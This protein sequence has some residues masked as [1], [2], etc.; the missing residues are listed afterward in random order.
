MKITRRLANSIK[1]TAVAEDKGTPRQPH[2]IAPD[3]HEALSAAG[4]VRVDESGL[5]H[6]TDE[7]REAAARYDAQRERANAKARQ[8][9]RDA[10]RCNSVPRWLQDLMDEP[11]R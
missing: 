7:G 1:A 11:L 9:R 4:Y 8:R 5:L 3:V 2:H 6:A 10:K